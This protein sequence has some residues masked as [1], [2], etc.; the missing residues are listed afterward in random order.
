MGTIAPY[1]L[2]Q[3][4]IRKMVAMAVFLIGLVAFPR[5]A[6]YPAIWNLT[7]GQGE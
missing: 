4:R 1:L 6:L 3:D 7:K 5:S 2:G